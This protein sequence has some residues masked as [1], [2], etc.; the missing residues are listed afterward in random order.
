MKYSQAV[1]LK[2][3]ILGETLLLSWV[4]KLGWYNPELETFGFGNEV[5]VRLL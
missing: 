4:E 5:G 1:P 2:M 3:V